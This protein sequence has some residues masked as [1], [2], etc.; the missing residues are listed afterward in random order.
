[1]STIVTRLGKG[2]ALTWQEADA[3][4]TNLNLDKVEEYELASSTGSSMVGYL[5]E[6]TGAVTTTVQDKLRESVSVKDFGAVGDGVT[7]DTAAVQAAIAAGTASSVTPYAIYFPTGSYR[8]TSSLTCGAYGNLLGET[9]RTIIV[10]DHGNTG[11]TLTGGI[12]HIEKMQFTRGA[13]YLNQGIN[14]YFNAAPEWVLEAVRSSYS[15]VGVQTKNSTLLSFK[16]CVMDY[17]TTGYLD[18]GRSPAQTW[19]NGQFYRNDYGCDLKSEHTFTGGAIELSLYNDAQLS[20]TADFNGNYNG[21]AQFYGVHFEARDGLTSSTDPQLLVGPDSSGTNA[22]RLTLNGSLFTGNSSNRPAISMRRLSQANI[23]SVGIS[24]Y[25]TP[26]AGI[27][28]TS[29]TG[30]LVTSSIFN[31][32]AK[33]TSISSA[34]K[35]TNMDGNNVLTN[36]LTI[37]D[38]YT[39]SA[40]SAL[41]GFATLFVDPADNDLK[42]IFAD[43][44]VKTI[45]TDTLS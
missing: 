5:P 8:I 18:E 6:G 32:V 12:G 38:P 31:T 21:V 23:T 35:W 28:G 27:V 25:G 42:I 29:D 11:L 7:D 26:S 3:N 19:V 13:S 36:S 40:P 22:I 14:L 39:P 1:M 43:G 44:K 4:F 2:T 41:T 9:R 20:V 37:R 24:G 15:L 30:R 16:D 33:P 45:V 34:T 17:N 10:F